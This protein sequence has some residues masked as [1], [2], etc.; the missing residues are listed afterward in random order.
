MYGPRL[1]RTGHAKG[2]LIAGGHL[3]DI[4]GALL[5]IV[6]V[7]APSMRDWMES[8]AYRNRAQGR[9]ALMRARRGED[10]GKRRGR[11]LG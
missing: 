7:L 2:P 9:A 3:V 6:A 1:G 4:V 11:G 8:A 10:P 5:S